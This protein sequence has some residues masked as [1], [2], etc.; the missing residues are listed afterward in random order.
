MGLDEK[1]GG[2]FRLLISINIEFD[3]GLKRTFK[4]LSG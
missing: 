1:R 4:P 3:I 2:I